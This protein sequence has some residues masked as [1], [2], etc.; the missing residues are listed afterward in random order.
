M[1]RDFWM[2]ELVGHRDDLNCFQRWFCEETDKVIKENDKFFL[3]GTH[4]LG[5][6]SAEEVIRKAEARLELMTAAARLEA[7]SEGVNVKIDSAVYVDA[8]GLYHYHVLVEAGTSSGVS[9][10]CFD[11]S[12]PSL[13]QRAVA[14]ADCDA[15]LDMALRLWGESSRSWPRLFR[16]VEEITSSF[17]PDPHKHMSEVLF[18]RDLIKSREDILRFRYSACE[19][20]IAGRDSRHAN[21]RYKM[22]Q[23]LRNLQNTTMTHHEAVA[24][25]GSVLS[26]AMR[27]KW[28]ARSETSTNP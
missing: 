28:E 19:P 1:T 23:E 20:N 11:S 15:H 17:E 4:L 2:V 16:I 6:K 9:V 13:P 27:R 3:T 25:V 10:R 7:A 22:P 14:I 18:S 12:I 24:L 21:A 5:C 26:R 8:A